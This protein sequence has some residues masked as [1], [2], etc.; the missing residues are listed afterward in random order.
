[1]HSLGN[2]DLLK[3]YKVAFLCSRKYPEITAAKSGLWADE[4]RE[5]GVCVISGYHSPIERDVLR[6]LLQGTQPVIIAL[7]KGLQKLDA[8]LSAHIDAAT[9]ASP[10]TMR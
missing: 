3:L 10:P 8:E 4:Q 5:Q 6:R 1:M 2:L 9:T 7:A